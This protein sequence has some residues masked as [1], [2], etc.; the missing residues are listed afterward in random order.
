M[1]TT[2]EFHV[3]KSVMD[4][5]EYFHYCNA[6]PIIFSLKLKFQIAITYIVTHFLTHGSKLTQELAVFCFYVS[7]V[8]PS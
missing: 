6:F 3:K 5:F 7:T 2:V 4:K 1:N 8:M